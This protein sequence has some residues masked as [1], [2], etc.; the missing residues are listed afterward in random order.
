M[1]M[2]TGLRELLLRKADT[3]ELQ[4]LVKSLPE[5]ILS[6]SVEEALEKMARK[7]D[8]ANHALLATAGHILPEV[9]GDHPHESMDAALIHDNLS[10]HLTHYKAALKAGDRGNADRHLEN[11]MKTINYG[12][13][14]EGITSGGVRVRSGST[15]K[16][17]GGEGDN[18]ISPT[19]WEMNYTGSERKG[20]KYSEDPKGWSR[21]LS[22]A[23]KPTDMFPDYQYM[24]HAPHPHHNVETWGHE[25]AYPFHD[26]QVNG[27]HVDIQDTNHSGKFEPHVLDS[28]PGRNH[29]HTLSS[30]MSRTDAE[31]FSKDHQSWLQGPELDSWLNSQGEKEADPEH[32]LRGMVPSEPVHSEPTSHSHDLSRGRR[33][34]RSGEA[35][36]APAAAALIEAPAPTAA[37]SGIHPEAEKI[38]RTLL[39]T[40]M[41]PEKIA[42][43]T[44]LP[45]DHIKNL[46]GK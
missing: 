37:P 9:A 25:G 35:P 31:K 16:E 20:S 23:R 45:V 19:P 18:L 34:I 12:R 8:S 4:E 46:A 15:A 2:L 42:E 29:A 27:K 24:E 26:L 7:G 40:G 10:H 5:D 44:K 6:V 1:A 36:A 28:H 30:K 22:Q 39:S 33:A 21:Q 43:M 14:L 11:A 13:K 17:M 38:I 41:A 32:H 3:P